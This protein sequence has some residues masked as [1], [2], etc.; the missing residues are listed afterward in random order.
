VQIAG[1]MFG[2]EPNLAAVHA[3]EPEFMREPKLL[4][5]SARSGI[6]FLIDTLRPA[7][8][9]MPSYLCSSMVDAVDTTISDIRFYEVGYSL[10]VMSLDWVDSVLPGSLV[11]FVAYFGFPCNQPAIKQVHSRG[12]LVL[13]DASQALLSSHLGRHSDF[14]L[15]SPRKTVGVPD[16]GVLRLLRDSILPPV[17]LS[18]PPQE[19][20]LKALE[21]CISRREFDKRD[22]EREWFDLFQQVEAFYPSGL[23]RMS[24]LSQTLL[25]RGFSYQTIADVRRS[26]YHYLSAIFKSY[27]LFPELDCDTVPLGFPIRVAKREEIRRFLFQ[28][29]IFPAVHWK[30]DECV[31]TQFEESHRLSRNIMTIP[32]DHRLTSD[33]V[34]RL[35]DV[36]GEALKSIQ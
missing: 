30:L 24:E 2:F 19:W 8:V 4:F 3:T 7:Q 29:A 6:K 26:H 13:E 35:A 22:G 18:Q 15:F 27:A 25:E 16:G 20:W 10:E 17:A 1:G 23:Y 12:A 34:A 14:L 31:P 11:V 33:D 28:H 5:V 36:L 21:A 32:C 9:W